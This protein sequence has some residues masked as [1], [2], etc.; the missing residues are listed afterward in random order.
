MPMADR[1]D[2]IPSL[3]RA[4]TDSRTLATAAIRSGWDVRRL[5]DA[6]IVFLVAACDENPDQFAAEEVDERFWT[7]RRLLQQLSAG[8]SRRHRRR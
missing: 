1:E 5:V 7:V 4:L 3:S 2:P 8:S 6:T